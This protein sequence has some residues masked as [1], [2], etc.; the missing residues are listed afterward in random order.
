MDQPAA[1]LTQN[2]NNK[3][4]DK[5]HRSSP[6]TL[7]AAALIP[8]A[9]PG[10]DMTLKQAYQ[11][12]FHMGASF[13][14]PVIQEDGQATLRLIASQFNSITAGNEMKWAR[15]QPQPQ[16]YRTELADRFVAFGSENGMYIVGHVLFW[17]NQT[18]AWVFE[19]EQ[20]RP[21]GREQL[22]SRMR[23]RVRYV[24]KRYKGR[25]HAWDVVNEAIEG[26]GTL[27]DSK[28]TQIIGDDFIEQAFRI[29]QEELPADM[30]LIYN[31]Y[32]MT[33]NG[34]RNAVVKLVRDLKNK[35]IRIDGIGMQGHWS[36]KAPSISDIEKSIIAFADTGVAV[37]IT[38][39]DIDVLPRHDR[40]WSGNADIKLQLQQDPRLN[41]YTD[42][43]PAEIQKELAVRY[44]DIF[45]L[46]LKHSDKIK[47]VTFWG[48]SDQYSWLN[49]WPIKGRTNYPLLFDREGNPKPAFHAVINLPFSMAPAPASAAVSS[50]FP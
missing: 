34:R 41:P 15:L 31:D 3:E 9:A 28:W 20:G 5:M 33:A 48:P 12:H 27:R 32:G 42:G 44:A 17:H 6:L 49:S 21:A 39:L 37:H 35:G 25:V 50:E 26:N 47:R 29:A 18:P 13:G 40:M 10:A 23:E 22:L 7:L 43:L 11:D 16:T 46:F 38:E 45:T 2:N 14:K 30:A 36:L 8:F 19:D 1:T 4:R 24:A